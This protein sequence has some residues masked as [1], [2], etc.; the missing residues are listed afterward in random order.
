[1]MAL[2]T[3][4]AV[5]A[6]KALGARVLWSTG[7]LIVL[8]AALLCG[9]MLIAVRGGDPELT[10]KLGPAAA[11]GDWPALLSVAAQITAAGGLLGFGVGIT[12][13]LGREFADQTV[14]GLFGLAVG[15]GTIAAAKLLVY[16]GWAIT[17]SLMLTAV[18]PVVAMIAGLGPPS[19][20]DLVGLMRQL[21]LGVLTGLIAVPA[22]WVATLGRGLLPGIATAVGILVVA[23]VSALAEFGSW[24]PFVAPAF[25]AMRPGEGTAIGLLT[26]PLVPAV[27]AAAI[28][29]AWRRIQLDR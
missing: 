11:S 29:W 27:F 28:I 19:G 4:L 20:T 25:W 8:G 15:R 10:A 17:V 2:R 16:E 13:L 9:G 22:G 21:A 5:E 3:A 7:V 23:Q 18:L 6:R 14:S 12:W 24:V 1:M 26:V